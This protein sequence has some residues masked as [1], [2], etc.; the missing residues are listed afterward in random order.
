MATNNTSKTTK[1]QV[2]RSTSLAR[3]TREFRGRAH[4][5]STQHKVLGRNCPMV[6][7]IWHSV[8]IY[9]SIAK[10]RFQNCQ[11]I[12]CTRSQ[13]TVNSRLADTSLLRTAVKSPETLEWNKL[14]L[15]R[16]R[17]S[18]DLRTLYSVPKSQFYCFLSRYSGYRA[19]SWNICTHIKSIFS[20]F[21][22]CVSLF[23]SISASSVHQSKFLHLFLLRPSL[24]SRYHE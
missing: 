1:K 14:P 9:R 18:T 23:L 16:T 11:V 4:V 13:L 21:R 3:R 7:T 5:R 2:K 17:L 8:K 24:Q 19:A 6:T 10:L 15:L 20:A 22:D 12:F